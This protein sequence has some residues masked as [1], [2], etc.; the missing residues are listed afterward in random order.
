MNI[1]DPDFWK[2]QTHWPKQHPMPTDEEFETARALYRAD[3]EYWMAQGDV[4]DFNM[5]LEFVMTTYAPFLWLKFF[6]YEAE[7]P[8]L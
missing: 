2:W 7:I 3:C 6:G 1:F 4:S 5:G 8:K